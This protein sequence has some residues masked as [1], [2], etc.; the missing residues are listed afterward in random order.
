MRKLRFDRDLLIIGLPA[1]LIIGGTFA[2]TLLLMR[3]AP[4]KEIVMATGP[5]G[6]A[7]HGHALKYREILERDGVTL[8]LWASGG[9]VEN[10]RRLSEPGSTV[11]VAF[12]QGGIAGRS[13]DGAL[14]SLGAMYLEPL[15]IFHRGGAQIGMLRHLR[16]KR[17]AIGDEGSGTAALALTLL[18][19][20]GLAEPPTTIINV[21]GAAAADM[22]VSGNIDVAFFIND[23]HSPIVQRLVHEPG[24]SLLSLDRAEAYV[25]QR[26]Y[27]THL[28]APRG[29]LDLQRDLPREDVHMVATTANLVVKEDLHPALAYLLLRAATEIH[30][31]PSLFNKLHAFPAPDDTELPLSAEATRYY[32]SGAP[33]LQR[34][35]PFWAANLTD[36][37]LVLLVP[38]IA[39]LFP[40]MRLLPALYRWRVRSRIYRWY[41]RLKEFEIELEEDPSRVGLQAMLAKL[42][43]IDDAVHNIE[44]PLAYSENLYVFRQH[45]DLVR[46][47]AQARL[48]SRG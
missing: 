10:L 29:V 45:I 23:A 3:P 14:Q 2:L 19:D 26:Y 27:L 1:I 7:Y 21:G 8:N 31:Q 28:V 18:Q 13:S 39:I 41:A 20:N 12:L 6:G 5:V 17:I 30:G 40:A 48:A 32:K 11:D 24:V 34:Y 43:A 4:P 36:R 38:A 15:W 25:R 33:L 46:Q 9:A 37:L 16:G 22:L 42:D 35:L 44:T 47:R